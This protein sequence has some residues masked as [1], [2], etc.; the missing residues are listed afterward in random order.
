VGAWISGKMGRAST[1]N[2][3]RM[4]AWT[5]L[6]LPTV[7]CALAIQ[8]RKRSSLARLGTYKTMASVPQSWS[9][10]ATIASATSGGTPIG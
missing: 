8:R 3:A 6:G 1:S 5:T 2:I 4:W 10:W 9:I 7:R